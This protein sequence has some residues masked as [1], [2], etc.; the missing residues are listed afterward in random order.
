MFLQ[1]V[2]PEIVI[3]GFHSDFKGDGNAHQFP[4]LL[5]PMTVDPMTFQKQL[6]DLFFF[7][8]PADLKERILGKLKT[9]ARIDDL[10][11]A[12]PAADTGKDFGIQI[13]HFCFVFRIV[14]DIIAKG[15]FSPDAGMALQQHNLPRIFLRNQIIAFHSIFPRPRAL[16]ACRPGATT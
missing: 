10:Q 13:C 8:D 1:H 11:H 4:H 5:Q 6:P 2:F 3:E 15:A 7:D 14:R 9:A 12:G 16:S